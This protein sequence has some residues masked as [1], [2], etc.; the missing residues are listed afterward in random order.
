MTIPD[1]NRTIAMLSALAVGLYDT[2]GD[3]C[4]SPHATRDMRDEY[5]RLAIGMTKLRNALPIYR[6]AGLLP[7]EPEDDAS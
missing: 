4:E 5:A 1:P 6:A 2:L 7:P 3:A